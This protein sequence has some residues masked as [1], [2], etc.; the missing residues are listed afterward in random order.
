MRVM[1][2]VKASPESEAGGMG[3]PEEFAEII[4]KSNPDG[5]RIRQNLPPSKE[6]PD[7]NSLQLVRINSHTRPSW[8][9]ARSCSRY[10]SWPVSP[11]PTTRSAS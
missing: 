2:I 8:M 11:S 1:V 4:I 7:Q 10:C 5:S 9:H 3:S 6:Y